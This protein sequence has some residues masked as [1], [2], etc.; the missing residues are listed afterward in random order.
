MFSLS[1]EILVSAVMNF[2]N[3]PLPIVMLKVVVSGT[4]GLH[5]EVWWEI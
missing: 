5:V 1:L 3:M 4:K 2:L